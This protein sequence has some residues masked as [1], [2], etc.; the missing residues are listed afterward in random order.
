MEINLHLRNYFYKTFINTLKFSV[1]FLKKQI[2][3]KNYS[4]R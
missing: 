1:E 2:Q 4:D 3:D